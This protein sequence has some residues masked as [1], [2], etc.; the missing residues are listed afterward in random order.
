MEKILA[1][2]LLLLL[3]MMRPPPQQLVRHDY[4]ILCLYENTEC[5]LDLMRISITLFTE[6]GKLVWAPIS[7]PFSIPPAMRYRIKIIWYK[8]TEDFALTSVPCSAP[9]RVGLR[10]QS[11]GEPNDYIP[12]SA[13]CQWLSKTLQLMT[14][15]Y[16][17]VLSTVGYWDTQNFIYCE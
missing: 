15:Q 3:A 1:A 14:N 9:C 7:V 8:S 13:I 16:Q 6:V 10:L 5:W 11:T 4:E 17:V 2:L 12:E